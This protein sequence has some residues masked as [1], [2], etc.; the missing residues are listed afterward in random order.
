MRIKPEKEIL[1]QLLH[2]KFFGAILQPAV[3]MK[4]LDYQFS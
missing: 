4:P 2:V 3:D 1:E